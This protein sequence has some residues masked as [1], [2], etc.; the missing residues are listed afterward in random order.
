MT[1]E[2][3]IPA[4]WMKNDGADIRGGHLPFG[5]NALADVMFRDG[6]VSRFQRKGRMAWDHIG[7]YSDI[8]AYRIPEG[9]AA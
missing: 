9:G 2:I 4:G 6:S 7:H 1:K 5:D 3:E 8:I